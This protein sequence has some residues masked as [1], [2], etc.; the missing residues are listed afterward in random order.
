MR[1]A[2]VFTV[3]HCIFNHLVTNSCEFS[4]FALV[5][6]FTYHPGGVEIDCVVQGHEVHV[7][8]G[9]DG[10][11]YKCKRL[12]ENNQNAVGGSTFF[13]IIGVY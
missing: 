11:L 10:V 8:L 3:Q 5:H 4:I 9:T 1:L 6:Y 13:I 2:S 12:K 7:S